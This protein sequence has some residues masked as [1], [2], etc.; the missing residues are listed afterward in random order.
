[1]VMTSDLYSFA[2]SRAR[3]VDRRHGV[4]STCTH[5]AAPGPVVPAP[6][7][8]RSVPRTTAA[9]SPPGSRPTCSITPSAPTR[10][11]LPSSR[12]TITT[13]GFSPGSATACA[14]STAARTSV[15]SVPAMP[16]RHHHARQ[17]HR[18]VQRQHRERQR[19]C[20]EITLQS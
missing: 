1:M 5:S 19:L 3:S 13:R 12:G 16:D 6:M 4:T 11:Y 15:P 17:Q 9:S 18:V 20:H 8:T 14:A 10:A 2:S 7:R